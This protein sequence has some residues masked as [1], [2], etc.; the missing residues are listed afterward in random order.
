[1]D[2]E[3][4]LFA[5][6]HGD[7]SEAVTLAEAAYR[8]RRTIFTADALGWALT[9]AGRPADALPYIDEARR[10]G[11]TSPALHVHAAV[12][13]AATGDN[14]GAADALR[15]AFASS[16]W[17]VPALRPE[18]AALGDRLGLTVPEDWRP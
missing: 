5:A 13:L 16:A 12:A 6:D 9:R 10:L 17:L 15:T 8:T 1:V 18:A 7:A 3:S 2:L 4:A 14:A 11:T